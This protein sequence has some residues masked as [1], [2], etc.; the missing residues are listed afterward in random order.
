MLIRPP[1]RFG[2]S[3]VSE[4]FEGAREIK[5]RIGIRRIERERIA[6]VAC[7]FLVPGEVVVDIS[8]IEMCFEEIGL[9][10]DR[11]FV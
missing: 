2:I 3:R 5:M 9:Q 6:I 7:R 11:A 10:A 4:L 8:E 1:V